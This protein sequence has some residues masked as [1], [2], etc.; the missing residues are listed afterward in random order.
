MEQKKENVLVNY[1][2]NLKTNFDKKKKSKS[3]DKILQKEG[4]EQQEKEGNKNINI[5]INND[6][7]GKSE[8]SSTD[9]ENKIEATY[10]GEKVKIPKKIKFETHSNFSLYEFLARELVFQIFHYPE[11]GFFQYNFN[12]LNNNITD[13][14]ILWLERKDTDIE[15]NKESFYLIDFLNNCF[16]NKNEENLN[17]SEK[18]KEINNKNEK[19]NISDELIN[20]IKKNSNTQNFKGDFDF[21]IPCVDNKLLSEIFNDKKL[22]PFIFYGNI[23]IDKN[24]EFDI[25]GE[26]K[27]SVD[28]HQKLKLQIKKYIMM[29]I[30]FLDEKNNEFQEKNLHFNYKR[31]KILMY[32]FNGE[33]KNFLKTMTTFKINRNKFKNLEEYKDSDSYK[34][35]LKKMDDNFENTSHFLHLIIHSG[36]AFIFLYIPDILTIK[37]KQIIDNN[38]LIKLKKQLEELAKYK[39]ESEIKIQE[40]NKILEQSNKILKQNEEFIKY[41]QESEKQRLQLTEEFE[42]YKRESKQEFDQYKEKMGKIIDNLNNQIKELRNQSEKN[43]KV[44]ANNLNANA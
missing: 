18:I 17:L 19:Q 20:L 35:I 5:I 34:S 27:E 3:K 44:D 8:L 26:V 41:K 33:Y 22:A 14:I 12:M 36:L 11:M 1:Y 30:D 2:F 15:K 10:K 39:E 13:N 32:V 6:S 43:K 4:E 21:I 28:S 24:Q 16:N 40:S 38:E 25:I 37:Y 29:I 7:P 31:K 23:D 42:K 9:K